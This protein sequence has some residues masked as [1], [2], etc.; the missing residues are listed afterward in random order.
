MKNSE[1]HKILLLV[2]SNEL[3]LHSLELDR[4]VRMRIDLAKLFV[5]N[6]HAYKADNTDGHSPN[7]K[8]NPVLWIPDMRDIYTLVQCTT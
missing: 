7:P 2:E 4:V 5:P 1:N 3:S 8:S 6:A